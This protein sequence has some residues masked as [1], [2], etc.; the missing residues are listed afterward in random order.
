MHFARAYCRLFGHRPR[1]VKSKIV[2]PS[3]PYDFRLTV[4]ECKTCHEKKDVVRL[5]EKGAF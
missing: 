1:Q 5:V 2:L 4:R 3:G